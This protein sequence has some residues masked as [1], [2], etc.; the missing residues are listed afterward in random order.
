MARVH[1]LDCGT[2]CPIGGRL[3]GG[4]HLLQRGL[5]VCHCLLVE[6][7]RDGLVLVD[8]GYGTADCDDP[9][10]LPR[11]FRAVA[12]PRLDRGQTALEQVRA[13][14][15]DPRDV[16]HVAVTHLD[17]DHAGGLPDFPWAEVHV[18]RR[19][20]DDALARRDPRARVRY[21]PNRF[22][23][24]PRW[25]VYE[26]EGDTWM[27]LPA[28][29]QLRGLHHD[30]VLV[31]LF[32]H[33]R[34]HTGVVVRRGARW[35]VHAGDAYFHHDELVPGGRPPL[36]LR[37]FAAVDEVDRAARLASI[38]ALQRLAAHDD[39]DVVCSHDPVEL[40]RAAVEAA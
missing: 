32:G 25:V 14:G 16:R 28:V 1:H 22:A 21:W 6:T 18:H 36:G 40:D 9:S 3:V 26:A 19:E 30:V 7:D 29:R 39:V 33:T 10:R 15:F 24:G 34:G 2:M 13:L 35:V 20:R 8:T 37:L 12:G 11:M 4:D 31:P 23:H 27:D 38:A 5:L 17:P